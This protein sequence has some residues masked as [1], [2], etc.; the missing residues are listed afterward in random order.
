MALPTSR[1]EPGI[2][3]V[4]YSGFIKVEDTFA[5]V[6]PVRQLAAE[7]GLTRFVVLVDATHFKGV[8]RFD[9]SGLVSVLRA[10]EHLVIARIVIGGSIVPQV[11]QMIIYKLLRS[12]FYSASSLD[13][14]IDIAR[15]LLAEDAK[16]HEKPVSE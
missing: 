1:I 4:D 16:T 8:D 7:D 5:A 9:I 13:K 2:Y 12:R 14:A 6:A 15:R 3:F 11:T 10:T